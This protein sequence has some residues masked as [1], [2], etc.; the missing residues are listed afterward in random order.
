MTRP[1]LSYG[2][3]GP[4]TR[5]L[6]VILNRDG[7]GLVN[8]GSFGP[9][10]KKAVIAFQNDQGLEPNG[11]VGPSTWQCLDELM[12][13]P[14]SIKWYYGYVQVI[15]IPKKRVAKLDFIESEGKFETLPHMMRRLKYKP[16]LLFNG[17]LYNTDDGHT[18]GRYINEGINVGYGY[19][20]KFGIKVDKETGVISFTDKT[21]GA[22]EFLG[23]GPTL[24]INGK[25]I[26][27][28]KDLSN[29]FLYKVHPRTAFAD[30]DYNYYLIMVHGRRSWLG[31]RGMTIPELKAFCKNVL[32]AKNA[33][34]WD[35]GG[36][37]MV[38]CCDGKILNKYLQVRAIANAVSLELV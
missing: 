31:H 28:T 11:I 17:S 38:I 24:I 3:N 20:S 12:A 25:E 36:S 15:T 5:L 30:D 26:N 7:Y 35:G 23:F 22:K 16:T 18:G 9:A 33:G 29:D 37:C 21:V 19:Y 14:F 34:N 4:N 32:K 8:D 2:S 6:Q 13:R 10:T 27:D 1:M